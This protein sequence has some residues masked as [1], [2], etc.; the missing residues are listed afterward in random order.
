M[1]KWPIQKI[2]GLPTHWRRS[3]GKKTLFILRSNHALP[4]KKKKRKKEN[5]TSEEYLWTDVGVVCND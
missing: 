1:I 4:K 3:K 5:K 2:V